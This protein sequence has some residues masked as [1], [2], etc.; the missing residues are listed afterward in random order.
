MVK[1]HADTIAGQVIIIENLSL[2]RSRLDVLLAFLL[3]NY[4]NIVGEGCVRRERNNLQLQR[5]LL[6]IDEMGACRRPRTQLVS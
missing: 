3:S 4:V 1:C 2:L 6:E 5:A